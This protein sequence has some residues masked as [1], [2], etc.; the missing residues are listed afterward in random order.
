M[1]VGRCKERF[2]EYMLFRYAWENGFG[3]E[4]LLKNL[5]EYYDNF[6]KAYRYLIEKLGYQIAYCGI[7]T[8]AREIL[9][10]IFGSCRMTYE[11]Y[12]NLQ[13]VYDQEEPYLMLVLKSNR[14]TDQRGLNAFGNVF[15]GCGYYISYGIYKGKD[16]AWKACRLEAKI[17]LCYRLKEEGF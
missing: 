10:P 8:S 6:S 1:N 4:I 7:T 17:E 14:Q 16:P 5:Y 15:A 11:K 12:L 9:E 3:E 13:K 2:C